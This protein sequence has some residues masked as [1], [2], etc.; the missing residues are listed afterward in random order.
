MT[1][2]R[3]ALAAAAILLAAAGCSSQSDDKPAVQA[4]GD[5]SCSGVSQ[6]VTD[7]ALKVGTSL[8]LSGGAATAGKGFEAGL[9]AAVAEVNSNGG[10]N[11]RK[12]D[13]VVL[14]DGFEAARSVA[15]IRR[16]G[17]EEKVF[18][19]LGPAGTANLPGSFSY[20]ERK[21]MP[22]FAPVLPPDPDK[23]E[24]WL[25]GTGHKDQVRV[26]ID[27]L[28]KEKKVK[29]VALLTQDNDL[30]KAFAEAVDEQAPKHDVKLVANEKLEPNSTDVDS[31]ILKLKAKNPDAVISGTDNA[32][33]ALLLKEARD[34]KW[35]TLIVGNS[36]SGGP[37]SPST[38]GPAGPAAEGFISSAILE[39][40]TSDAPEVQKYREAMK[41]GGGA[42]ADNSFALQNYASAQVF[43]EIVKRLGD[44]VCWAKFRAEGEKLSDFKTGLIPPVTFGA[45]PGGHSG[46]KGA[47]IAQ[48]TG[49]EWKALTEFVEPQD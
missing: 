7:T 22:M 21:G 20:L 24:V 28:A 34:L 33:T 27:W 15:N 40:P 3:T 18:A 36:S 37:G 29:T 9:K 14:D 48:Y 32:Q 30:G 17:E 35:S 5:G 41:A 42:E 6:G 13:L 44:D 47:R 49:K 39:F 12:V 31:A 1:T 23:G 8:P 38:V 43:F 16:L 25:L 2:R 45:L 4:G 26:I 10:I 19:V 11:G 46:T